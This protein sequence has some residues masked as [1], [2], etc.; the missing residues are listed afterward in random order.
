MYIYCDNKNIKKIDRYNP[1]PSFDKFNSRTTI[2]RDMKIKKT[3]PHINNNSNNSKFSTLI[4]DNSQINNDINIFK[5]RLHRYKNIK[6]NSLIFRNK[7][8]DNINSIINS[9]S[10]HKSLRKIK[11]KRINIKN[12]DKNSSSL[13]YIKPTKIK[14]FRNFHIALMYQNKLKCSKSIFD[15]YQKYENE[16]SKR[17]NIDELIMDNSGKKMKTGIYGPSDSIVSVIRARMERLKYDHEYIGVKPEYRELIKD[18]IMDAEVKLK[19]K[20]K[21]YTKQKTVDITSTMKKLQKY[22]YISKVN[23][24]KEINKNINI[25]NVIDDGQIMVNLLNDAFDIYK[26]N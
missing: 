18:E 12:K 26:L 9:I 19:R 6:S 15:E 20:P 8:I 11:L 24:V 1:F 21:E 14:N 13:N 25:Q 22:K 16:K 10:S 3:L 5:G 7:S 2:F 17:I 4:L 23:K